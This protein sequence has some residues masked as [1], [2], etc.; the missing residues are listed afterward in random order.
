MFRTAL[1]FAMSLMI[2]ALAS[3]NSLRVSRVGDESARSLFESLAS[4]KITREVLLT[5][6]EGEFA[7]TLKIGSQIA[8]VHNPHSFEAP[9]QGYMCFMSTDDEGGVQPL[10]RHASF[11]GLLG[12]L[13]LENGIRVPAEEFW[14]LAGFKAN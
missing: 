14:V 8:C 9:V 13:D 10:S 3:A 12:F 4:P 11:T 7:I 1:V 2:S 5:T 6:D